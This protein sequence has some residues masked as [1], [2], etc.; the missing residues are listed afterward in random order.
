MTAAMADRNQTFSFDSL[1]KGELGIST[2][3][4]ASLA[5][6]ACYCL[7][8]K[9]HVNPVSLHL[10]GDLPALATLQWD[11]TTENL[12]STYADLPNS[13]E[14]GACGIALAVTVKVTGL[15]RVECSARG[16]GVDY[17]LSEGVGTPGPFQRAARL[18]VSGIL[19][20]DE[21]TISASLNKKLTQTERSDK[22]SL[23]AYIAIVEFGL[24]NMR[25]VKKASGKK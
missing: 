12:D 11:L 24:P 19:E 13:T 20:G 23:P 3:Y 8:L 10:S 15:H 7:K 2:V 22:T 5:E 4:G 9:K 25:L 1:R 17:W 6:A 18:E 14:H 16:T 21:G